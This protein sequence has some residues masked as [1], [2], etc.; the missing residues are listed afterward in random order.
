MHGVTLVSLKDLNYSNYVT[1]ASLRDPNSLNGIILV[2]LR[3]PIFSRDDTVATGIV[4]TVLKKCETAGAA[5][6]AGAAVTAGAAEIDGAAE[7]LGSGDSCD[8]CGN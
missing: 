1:R 8:C 4:H 6:I 5:K 7:R 3:D 2:S